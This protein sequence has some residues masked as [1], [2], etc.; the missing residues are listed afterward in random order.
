MVVSMKALLKRSVLLAA[1]LLVAAASAAQQAVPAPPQPLPFSHKLHAGKLELKCATCHRNPDPGEKMGFAAPAT[2]M[3]CHSEVKADSPHI[4]KLAAAAKDKTDIR[5][6]R[7]Y[8]I[9]TFVS[10]SH[11]AHLAAGN[12]CAECHGQVKEREQLF[13]EA[14]ISMSACMNCH[15]AKKASTDCAYCHDKLN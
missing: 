10:F 8:E 11:R 4:Q 2:C 3:Q 13:R 1:C 9:P 12:N 7:V 14:D 5:W 15:A 6:V